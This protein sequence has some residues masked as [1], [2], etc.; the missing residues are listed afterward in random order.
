[1][2]LRIYD[3]KTREKIELVPLEPGK[4]GLYVCGITPYAPSHVG[5]ARS[6]VAFDVVYRWLKR[7]YEVTFVRNVTEVEDKLIRA[8]NA[9]GNSSDAIAER[10]LRQY[11]AD[12]RELNCLDPDREPKVTENIEAIVDMVKRLV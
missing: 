12:L 4:V 2:G 6:A 7:K 5:H 9:E 1:M 10:F 8:A 11:Q 3:T